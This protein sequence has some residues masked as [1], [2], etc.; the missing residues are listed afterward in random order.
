MKK[1]S[2]TLTRQYFDIKDARFADKTSLENGV[3][4]ISK[5]ELKAEVQ[6]LM[7]AVKSVD[8]EIVKPGE[9]TRIIHLLT[10]VF[11]IF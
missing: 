10:A 9:N 8:F 1:M 2:K 6:S 5:E 11:W 7:K 4:S 3:L